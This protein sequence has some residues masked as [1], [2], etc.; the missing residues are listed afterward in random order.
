M[1]DALGAIPLTWIRVV[2]IAVPLLLAVWVLLLPAQS[3][4]SPNHPRRWV[5]NLKFWA[6]L[7]LLVQ[8]AIY[9]LL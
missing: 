1:R 8:V 3:G 9:A 7:A 2:F 6:A 4:V 5:G